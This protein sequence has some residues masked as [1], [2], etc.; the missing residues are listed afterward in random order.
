MKIKRIFLIGLV[1][2]LLPTSPAVAVENGTDASGNPFVVPIMTRQTPLLSGLCS[3]ALIAPWIVVTAAHCVL[4]ANGL[5]TTEV[6]IGEAGGDVSTAQSQTN[7]VKTIQIT[8][9]YKTGANNNVGADDL[10]FLTLSKSMVLSTPVSLAS[11]SEMLLLREASTPLKIIGYG[12]VSDDPSVGSSSTPNSFQGKQVP[13]ANTL[14]PNSGN[15]VSSVGDVCKGDSGSPVLSITASKVTLVG[16]VT[17]GALNNNCTKKQSDGLYYTLFT[18][19]GRYANLAF[20][21]TVDSMNSQQD[22]STKATGDAQTQA[23]DLISQVNDLTQNNWDL[24]ASLEEASQQIKDLTKKY[25]ACIAS[26][27]KIL[28]TKKGKLPVGC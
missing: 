4:D 6:F 3:G 26:A 25:T 8:S 10:A 9:S 13:L 7:Q 17:G 20:A 12:R 19:V 27:K 24:T 22:Q 18:L 1:L 28:T 14:Y 11:E 15:M 2:S 16:I 23:D 5:L 21:A